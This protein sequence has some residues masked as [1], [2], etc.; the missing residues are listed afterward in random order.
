MG[1]HSGCYDHV[2]RYLASK[3]CDVLAFDLRGHGQ[4]GG[5]RGHVD[6][7]NQFLDDVEDL[8]VERRQ[9]GLRVVMVAHSL[10]GLIASAYVV[11]G[12]PKPDLLV[13]SAPAL[14]ANPPAWQRIAAPILNR[15]S[16]NKVVPLKIEPSR[17]TGDAEKQKEY[18]DDPLRLS[19][20]TGRFGYEVFAAIRS[21]S[22]A[23]DRITMPTYV[24]HGDIDKVVPIRFT[25]PLSALPNVEFRTWPGLRHECFNEV[26]RNDVIGEMASWIGS[27]L[28][29]NA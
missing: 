23:I 10:G 19:G 2:G 28:D 21:T 26:E 8:V 4:S 20:V 15:V 12:R 22:V 1:E 13:L 27:K 5:Q 6:H 18:F 7:F 29:P 16:P 25:R 9:L 14:G 11:S 3:G 24:L 17:L